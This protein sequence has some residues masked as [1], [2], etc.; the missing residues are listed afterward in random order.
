[1]SLFDDQPSTV[2]D[3]AHKEYYLQVVRLLIDC[4]E[5]DDAAVRKMIESDIPLDMAVYPLVCEHQVPLEVKSVFVKL[6]LE[7][8][9]PPA[10]DAEKMAVNVE[11]DADAKGRENSV[12]LEL[13]LVREL[14]ADIT[15]LST[16]MRRSGEGTK[17][18]ID[19]FFFKR[20]RSR[21]LMCMQCMLCV[22]V[23][24]CMYVCMYVCVC[25]CV[26]VCARA[27]VNFAFTGAP[28]YWRADVQPR[29]AHQRRNRRRSD[30]GSD[31]SHQV[32]EHTGVYHD[33]GPAGT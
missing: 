33:K 15:I 20:V 25:V 10:L 19:P 28:V 16:Q 1:M 29:E 27:Y 18:V 2:G 3:F 32:A 23:C 6:L 9:F 5:T 8:Y 31:C 4:C 12:Q 21:V 14:T 22:C 7:T 11:G 30:G 26:C 17:H 13:K 24:V